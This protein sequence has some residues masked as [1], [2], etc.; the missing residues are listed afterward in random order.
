MCNILLQY[1][2]ICCGKFLVIKS[3]FLK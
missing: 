1:V 2:L 3:I